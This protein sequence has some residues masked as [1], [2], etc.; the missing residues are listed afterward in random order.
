MDQS[1]PNNGLR[2][3]GMAFLSALA[4]T[5]CGGGGGTP[6][7]ADNGALPSNTGGGSGTGSGGSNSN[8]T[9]TSQSV[10]RVSE[11]SQSTSTGSTRQLLVVDSRNHTAVLKLD[12][13]AHSAAGSDWYVSDRYTAASDGASANID[14]AS[15]LY[16]IQNRHVTRIDLRGTT[17]G[18]PQTVSSISDACGFARTGFIDLNLDGTQSWLEVATAGPDGQ[19]DQTSDNGVVLVDSNASATQAGIQ[20]GSNGLELI[21]TIQ[22]SLSS[23]ATGILALNRDTAKLSVYST[24]LKTVLY[25]VTV[26]DHVVQK[27]ERAQSIG[28]LPSAPF[29]TL[30]QLGSSLYVSSVSNGQM[31][32]GSPALQLAAP[33]SYAR[34]TADSQNLYL[35]NGTDLIVI[36]P[37]GSVSKLGNLA[38]AAGRVSGMWVSQSS[39]LVQ[40]TLDKIQ[41]GTNATLTAFS[42]NNG[43]ATVL[44]QGASPSDAQVVGV[45]NDTVFF[46]KT[47]TNPN[48]S[49]LSD[50]F[51][52]T[53]QGATPSPVATGVFISAY[54]WS[55]QIRLGGIDV[56]QAV[57]CEPLPGATDCGNAPLLS[58]NLSTEQKITLGTIP[59]D[60]GW[61]SV[62]AYVSD[63]PFAARTNLIG[64]SRYAQSSNYQQDLVLWSFNADTANSLA[65]VTTP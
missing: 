45:V 48:A 63:E 62:L 39:V 4:L 42:K 56:L 14:G 18:T 19:C 31:V 28:H 17:V 47:S 27:N 57:W 50:I 26:S 30:I 7:P 43:T 46:R 11:T 54:M 37:T 58:Y 41:P 6:A 10:F 12:L 16:V 32:L 35:A 24:D 60:A 36:S 25:P 9:S 52:T 33:E 22:D 55:P 1:R 2:V 65:K 38:A 49:W 59:L 20:G 51:K 5:A 21:E 64:L 29:Q 15:Q 23:P 13:P 53:A 44:A 8:S 40:Q 34:T 3:A 61:T